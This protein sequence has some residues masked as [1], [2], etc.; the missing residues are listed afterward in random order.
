MHPRAVLKG[1]ALGSTHA[2]LHAA[3]ERARTAGATALPAITVGT[4]TYCGDDALA[5]AARE[6]VTHP[7]R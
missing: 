4:R 3:C 2:A 1:V 5:R 6:I 7:A